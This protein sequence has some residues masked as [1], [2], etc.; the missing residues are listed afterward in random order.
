MEP[1]ARLR[2]ALFPARPADGSV[3]LPGT[4]SLKAPFLSYSEGS[5]ASPH[6]SSF[7]GKFIWRVSLW[8]TTHH[9]A[10]LGGC[11]GS[12]AAQ[13]RKLRNSAPA[14]PFFILAAVLSPSCM[15]EAPGALLKR[16]P[17]ELGTVS[18][19]LVYWAGGPA[20]GWR[21]APGRGFR[22]FLKHS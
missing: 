19:N 4:S 8:G 7:P 15:L 11:T 3:V 13:N 17:G 16:L 22:Q 21:G 5:S 6:V 14:T 9:P 12:V 10:W 2:G 1:A 18:P 20:R